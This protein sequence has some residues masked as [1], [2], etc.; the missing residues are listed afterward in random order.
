MLLRCVDLIRT[1]KVL[2]EFQEGVCGG[3]FAPTVTTNRILRA[4]YYWP[5]IFKD[6]YVMII[7][8]V[9]CQRFSGEM[10]RSTILL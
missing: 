6:S 8:C 5:T 2:E 3:N 4:D 9:S 1:Q 10:K 7:K